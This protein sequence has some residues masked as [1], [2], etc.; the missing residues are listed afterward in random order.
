[1]MS[2]AGSHGFPHQNGADD[3]FVAGTS[4]PSI[5]DGEAKSIGGGDNSSSGAAVEPFEC[6]VCH[7][8]FQKVSF[9]I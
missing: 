9:T 6:D 5:D 8:K 3:G 2:P 1:M 7:K 4:A